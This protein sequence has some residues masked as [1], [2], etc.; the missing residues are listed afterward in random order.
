MLGHHAIEAPLGRGGTGDVYRA[1]DPRVN[2]PV[3]IKIVPAVDAEWRDEFDR[4]ATALARVEHPHLCRLYEVG[5]DRGIDYLVMEYLE[6]ETLASRVARGPLPLAHAIDVAGQIAR[7]L[8]HA[9]RL[10]LV[11]GDLRPA[12][13]MLTPRDE[14]HAAPPY[15]RLLDLGL[16]RWLAKRAPRRAPE[17]ID[18]QPFDERGDLCALGAMLCE[19][20]TGRP[21]FGN[22]TPSAT[23]LQ[24]R[25][26]VPLALVVVVE[27]C[28]AKDPADRWPSAA[29]VAD[30]L[31]K[32]KGDA[33]RRHGRLSPWRLALCAIARLRATT[34]SS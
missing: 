6:G 17:Q 16:A 7:A 10:G 31:Q 23:L 25:P 32:L 20:I 33:S 1:R 11:H 34:R 3:A 13:V 18:G 21:A 28:L 30:A 15:S 29:D 14:E 5:H 4:E 24:T 2:R 26:E 12:N 27:R 22:D 9:H 8:A 19:M